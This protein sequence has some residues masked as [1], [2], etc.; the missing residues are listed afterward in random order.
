MPVRRTQLSLRNH[1]WTKELYAMERRRV[2]D[3]VLEEESGGMAGDFAKQQPSA[4]DGSVLTLILIFDMSGDGD[5]IEFHSR[6]V[7]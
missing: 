1:S 4:N 2:Q 7:V 3:L 5:L 6:C